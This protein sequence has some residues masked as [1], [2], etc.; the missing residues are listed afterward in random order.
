M[1]IHPF[2]I[3]PIDIGEKVQRSSKKKNCPERETTSRVEAEN[4]M[5]QLCIQLFRLNLFPTKKKLLHL[6]SL[7]KQKLKKRTHTHKKKKEKREGRK[8]GEIG[9]AQQTHRS[10]LNS[11]FIISRYTCEL[12]I[13]M[14][15]STLHFNFELRFSS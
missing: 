11:R 5:Q 1:K 10:A 14:A 15:E 3:S 7:K 8:E 2:N 13:Y 6:S 4:G 9:N 12:Y